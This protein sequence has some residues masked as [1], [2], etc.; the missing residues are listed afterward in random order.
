MP[1]YTGGAFVDGAPVVNNNVVIF[2]SIGG[3][4]YGID[5]F[6]RRLVWEHKPNTTN[7]TESE[8][9]LYDGV[10][11]HDGGDQ[12]IYAL[13]ATDGSL[14]W[15][16]SFGAKANRDLLVTARRVFMSDGRTLYVFDRR[17][18]RLMTQIE[19][20]HTADSFFASPAAYANGQIFVT[21]G[22]GAWSF[23]EP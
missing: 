2:E 22:D 19:Q 11:Y 20:P 7:A 8:T 15:R 9:E 3:H 18:G 6:T 16:A 21:V 1:T 13:R 23:D 17:N 10:V 14:V 12:N 5:R 4:E